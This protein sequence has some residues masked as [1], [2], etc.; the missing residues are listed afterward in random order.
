MHVDAFLALVLRLANGIL[1]IQ[2]PL[3][4]VEADEALKWS[5]EAAF[6]AEREGL[7]PFELIGIARNETDFRPWLVG[8]DGKDCGLTQIRVTYSKYRCREL[9]G[10]TRKA[11]EEAASKLSLF[12][13]RCLKRSPRD[14]T[15]CRI[16]SYNSGVRYARSGWKG[17][18]WLRVTCF[19]EAARAGVT[20]QGDCRKVKSRGDIAR[21]LARSVERKLAAAQKP[22]AATVVD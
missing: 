4:D 17:R 8:P 3:H 19:A 6:H 9:R 14:V 10:D 12:Q 11:F 15:R 5:I 13:K 20:P 2:S 22:P 18:Y 21:L 1:A 16:N 7:D